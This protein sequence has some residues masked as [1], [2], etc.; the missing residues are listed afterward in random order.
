MDEYCLYL[1]KSRADLDAEA[2]GEGETLARH[3]KA[4]LELANRLKL[5]ITKIYREIVSGD[6][7]AARP[8]MQELLAEVDEGR[9]A[10][11]LVMEVERLARGDT[12]DQGIVAQAFKYSNTEIVTPAKIYDPSNEFDEEYFEFGLFMSRREYKTINRRLQ[13]GR[14]ASVKEGKY[15]ANRAPYGYVRVKLEHD[16]GFTLQPD[17]EQ[18]PVIRMIFEW[19]TRGEPQP[20]GTIRRIGASLITRRLNEMG[21]LAQKGKAWSVASVRDILINPVFAGML[22][23]NW[24]PH[25]KRV[26][27]GKVTME[28]PR[29][30]AEK[31]TVI[32]G[33]HEPLI[34]AA[35]FDLAQEYMALNRASSEPSRKKVSNPLSG[36][37]VCGVCG[38]R[39]QRRPYTRD[40][41]DSLIC[42]AT[43]CPNVSAPLASVEAR[44]LEEL[45]VW[46]QDYKVKL[47]EAPSQSGSITMKAK[48][49]LLKKVTQEL[50][51]LESQRGNLH[52][53]LERGVYDTETFLDRSRILAERISQAQQSIDTLNKDIEAELSREESRKVIIP[54]VERLLKVYNELPS[55]HAKNDMLKEVLEKVVYT[56]TVNGRW[57]N[58]PDDFTLVLYP[59]IPFSSSYH[60]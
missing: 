23:W 33:L 12:I 2:R 18:A 27:N 56:K 26:V 7:I 50:D 47:N 48:Q 22:R 24:R 49:S 35:T 10:G 52:D 51:G 37:I 8:V 41:A 4:L 32:K 13:R 53:L 31:C 38:R 57:H 42:Y 28:R 29:N 21:I 19:Y 14:L 46:I 59:R 44:L 58:S 60:R 40:Q 39:M 36:L 11:V 55:P 1:R 54:R 9:W 17:P 45:A 34:D 3:E 5:N 15:V 16:K 25:V 6:T 43:S 30:D 20:D